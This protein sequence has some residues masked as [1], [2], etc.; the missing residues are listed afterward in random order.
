MILSQ[1]S[2][3]FDSVASTLLI[4]ESGE[5]FS[6][7]FIDYDQPYVLQE[8]RACIY[9]NE[10]LK[11]KYENYKGLEIARIP[12]KLNSQEVKEYV[13]IRNLVLGALSANF[14]LSS[15]SQTIA[16]GTKT[17]E[18][19]KD[20]AYSFS[21]CS[22][23]FWELMSHICSYASE[24]KTIQFITPL[25]KN[26]VALTKKEVIDIIV[27]SGINIKHLWSCYGNA[28][29]HCG[30]CHHCKEIIKAGYWEDLER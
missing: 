8:Q 2:G 15:N 29:K 13:P 17:T 23:K 25:I 24:D 26:N 20:D 12:L 18:V 28:D 4:A 9:V 1:L 6:C 3:G 14:A 11:Q 16:V 10:F 22:I 5:K 27:N 19:R 30:V 7:L 21:D